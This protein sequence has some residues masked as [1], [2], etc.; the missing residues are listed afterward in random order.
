MEARSH[1]GRLI[2][3]VRHGDG[4]RHGGSRRTA[5]LTDMLHNQFA[6]GLD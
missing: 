3:V 6:D 4:V 1:G 5:P 2:E